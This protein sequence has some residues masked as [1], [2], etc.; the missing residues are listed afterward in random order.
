MKEY[1]AIIMVP[2]LLPIE[3]DDLAAAELI[4]KN[5]RDRYTSVKRPDGEMAPPYLLSIQEINTHDSNAETD[6]DPVSSRAA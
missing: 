3:T 4:A 2:V 1:H 6:F 5:E